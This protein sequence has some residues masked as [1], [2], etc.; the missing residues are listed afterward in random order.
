MKK[1]MGFLAVSL[2]VGVNVANAADYLT[3]QAGRV[4]SPSYGTNGTGGEILWFHELE[5]ASQFA[6]GAGLFNWGHPPDYAKM[7]GAVGECRLN[8]LRLVSDE[9]WFKLTINAGAFA[10]N[11][12]V[13]PKDGDGLTYKDYHGLGGRYGLGLSVPV[14]KQWALDLSVYNVYV[15]RKDMNGESLGNKLIFLGLTYQLPRD[16][17]AT[18]AS[19][20]GNSSL[21]GKWWAGFGYGQSTENSYLDKSV[22]NIEAIA[23]REFSDT[24]YGTVRI[25]GEG[26]RDDFP[27]RRCVTALAMAHVLRLGKFEFDTGGGLDFCHMTETFS[28]GRES[29]SWNEVNPIWAGRIAYPVRKTVKLYIANYR[30]MGKRDKNGNGSD[31][32]Q[33]KGIGFIKKF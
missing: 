2:A 29:S 19:G 23:D 9:P 21:P 22:P 24:F 14:S 13:K 3:V 31:E 12:T 30:A 33:Y 1:F 7:D 6:C 17:A 28:D 27:T 16:G 26:K 20:F 11:G 25:F 18:F 15:P 5:S 10:Y 32:D 8:V 4:H